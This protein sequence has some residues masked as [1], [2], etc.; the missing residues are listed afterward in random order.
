[1]VKKDNSNVL[2]RFAFLGHINDKWDEIFDFTIKYFIHNRYSEFVIKMIKSIKNN[3]IIFW[4][5]FIVASWYWSQ[6]LLGLFYLLMLF[7]SI[8]LSLLV[9]QNNSISSNARRLSKNVIL[10]ALTSLNLIG[11][12]LS[13][14]AVIFIY[15]EW[16]K[17]INILVFKTI[18]FV[19]KTIGNFFPGIYLMYPGIQLFSFDESDMTIKSNSN[20]H[21]INKKSKN[22]VYGYIDLNLKNNNHSKISS[23]SDTDSSSTSS[24]SSTKSNS[25]SESRLVLNSKSYFPTI[26]SIKKNIVKSKNI[27]KNNNNVKNIP[28]K[29]KKCNKN[30]KKNKV[31]SSEP[32]GSEEV[33]I[34][35]KF[36]LN[37]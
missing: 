23:D 37:K 8:I 31:D 6:L 1:M 24:T 15:M 3:K 22:N 26:S 30:D 20:N 19:L 10:I 27:K 25:T 9:I 11:G 21:K 12:I 35:T 13:L 28:K 16:S 32:I 18:K 34:L 4:M 2:D 17:G 14:L 36:G 7:D 33:R 29:N 5:L